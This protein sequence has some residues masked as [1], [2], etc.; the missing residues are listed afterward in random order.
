MLVGED[1]DGDL[2]FDPQLA[3]LVQEMMGYCLCPHLR[4]NKVF[5][6]QGDGANGKSVL[7][8]V[9][10]AMVGKNQV[11]EAFDVR[12]LD[13]ETNNAL[14]VNK[15]VAIQS[16][17]DSDG[18]IPDGKLKTIASGEALVGKHLY[19]DKFEFTPHATL[20]MA[21]N[22]LPA[23]RDRS[24]GFWRRTI[25]IPFNARFVEAT[26]AGEGDNVADPYLEERLLRELPAILNFAHSGLQRLAGNGWVFT[27]SESSDAAT[28]EVRDDSDNV[29]AWAR[30]CIVEGDG[31]EY[32]AN[33][34]YPM[35]RGHCQSN[36]YS[37]LS[38]MK[39]FKR[40]KH[41]VEDGELDVDI[42]H[43]RRSD[44]NCYVGGFSVVQE[45]LHDGGYGG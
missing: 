19:R 40:F 28:N 9:I 6:L 24:H 33:Q 4:A 16:E 11:A 25:V 7:L 21:G 36:G 1:G 45:D 13:D 23:T 34:L 31:G 41:I 38:S 10:S 22:S 17:L 35:Y 26:R 12:R 20:L 42:R 5:F 30:R 29:L 18:L 32:T 43:G 8:S 44:A 39:F 15:R 37:P 3:C 14:L 27:R 2:V